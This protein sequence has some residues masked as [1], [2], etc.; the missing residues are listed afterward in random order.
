MAYVSDESGRWE[1]YIGEFPGGGGSWQISAGGGVEPRW[2]PDGK[3]LFYVSPNGTLMAVPLQFN[4]QSVLP[5][6]PRPLFTARFGEFGAEISGQYMRP[7]T[8]AT[9]SSSTSLSKKPLR[10]RSP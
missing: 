4:Q 2:R 10:R 7:A 6:A 1:V 3:E 8:A 5:A 9:N